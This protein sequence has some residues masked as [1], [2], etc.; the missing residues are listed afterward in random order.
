MNIN[1]HLSILTLVVLGSGMA[2][3]QSA[4]KDSLKT[5]QL[6]ELVVDAQ[7]QSTSATVSTY[8]PTPL[9]KNA[10]QTAYDLLNRMGIPQLSVD[11]NGNVSTVT[12]KEVSIFIDF[13]PA[14]GQ[15]LTG[16]LMKDVKKVEYYDYPSD[17]RFNGKTHVVNFIMQKYEYGG[18]TKLNATEY[19]I[20]NIGN[21]NIF[22][23]FQYK[24]MTYSLGVGGTY[25][26]VNNDYSNTV[27]TYRLPQADG[28]I[29]QFERYSVTDDA[30]LRRRYI[31]PTFKA[32]YSSDKIVIRNTIGA[33]FDNMPKNNSSGRVYYVP[34]DYAETSFSNE[35]SRR[36]NS[37][38]YDGYM[39]FL[40]P[41]NNSIVFIPYYSYSHSRQNSLY[42][43]S[44]SEEYLNDATDYTHNVTGDLIFS[45]KFGKWGNLNASA[46]ANY[47]K[48]R[49]RYYGTANL[50]EPLYSLNFGPS[51]N[52]SLGIG[53]FY[54]T[55]GVGLNYVMSKIGDIKEEKT[56]PW[57]DVSLQYAINNRNSISGSFNYN[58][59]VPSMSYRSSAVI[60]A[61]P[62][63]SYTGNPSLRPFNS[64]GGG[65]QYLWLPNNNFYLSVFG[66]C[67]AVA[68][69]YAYV[70]EAS[71]EGIL[72]TLQQPVGNYFQG[73]WGATG[74]LRLLGRKL[75]LTGQLAGI[76]ARSSNQGVWSKTS[77]LW[78]LQAH[79]YLNNWY[80]GLQ[81]FSE[82]GEPDG[83]VTEMWSK[84]KDIY[85]AIVGWGNSSWNI[86]GCLANPFRWNWLY[87]TMTMQSPNYSMEQYKYSTS[88]HCYVNLSVTY[89]IGYGKKIEIS[90]EVTQ[91]SGA[92]SSILK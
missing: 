54:G 19:F 32:Q 26:S 1:Y 87:T 89:T 45:H 10:S 28:S 81:Y 24:K 80:F 57:V 75:Q 60:Q 13:L 17:P 55:V 92:D 16:M 59:N 50:D 43:E 21:F 8:V 11:I 86:K 49:T 53:N 40:L 41:H 33:T 63:M 5:K 72:R 56:E 39:S 68:N 58:S 65:L 79:Y 91:L 30:A 64:Y 29:K 37:V 4:E 66:N 44:P 71:P 77:V 78:S 52:Y 23:K 73:V 62:L 70:Y 27:E 15:E 74:T 42:R 7:L 18:Y 6:D 38:T 12:G 83:Y 90:D 61:N 14:D 48:S 76:T 84:S 34:T 69:R 22:S 35:S 31:W 67:F 3:A 9:Q 51:I 36:T 46:K 2:S 25:V 82:R 88:A 20:T 85:L 47:T